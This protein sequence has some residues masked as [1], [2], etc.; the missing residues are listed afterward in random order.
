[1]DYERYGGRLITFV[2]EYE[3]VLCRARCLYHMSHGLIWDVGKWGRDVQTVSCTVVV[4]RE[5][6]VTVYEDVPDEEVRP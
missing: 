5:A 1:M 3:T 2:F 4:P 6:T